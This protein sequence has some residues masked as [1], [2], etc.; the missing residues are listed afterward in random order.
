MPKVAKKTDPAMVERMKK[1]REAKAKKR[2]KI[3]E[4]ISHCNNNRWIN[5]KMDG[6]LI[7]IKTKKILKNPR[8]SK[9]ECRKVEEPNYY[10]Q[11]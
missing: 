7:K 5:A 1:A 10:E 8:G 3:A 4:G 2:A 9:I 11:V 6:Q